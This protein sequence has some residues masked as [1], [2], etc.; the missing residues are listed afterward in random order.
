[1]NMFELNG[2]HETGQRSIFKD[3]VSV[4]LFTLLFEGNMV[5]SKRNVAEKKINIL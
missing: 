4:F 2:G 5:K 1:M 3:L